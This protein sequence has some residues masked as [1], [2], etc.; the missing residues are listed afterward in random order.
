MASKF[1]MT[2]R[3]SKK[4]VGQGHT[5]TLQ[6]SRFATANLLKVRHGLNLHKSKYI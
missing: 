1:S 2:I 4:L 3:D 5:L 6:Q